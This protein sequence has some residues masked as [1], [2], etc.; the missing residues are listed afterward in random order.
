[1]VFRVRLGK[2]DGRNGELHARGCGC[3]GSRDSLNGS[4]N[5]VK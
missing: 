5:L 4:I 3:R 2:S 1:V